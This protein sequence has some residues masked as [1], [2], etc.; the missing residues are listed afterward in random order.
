MKTWEKDGMRGAALVLALVMLV[1]LSLMGITAV[2]TSGT[3]IFIA[4]NQRVG[5]Q[6][7]YCADAGL[8]RVIADH[9]Y[10]LASTSSSPDWSNSSLLTPTGSVSFTTT[11]APL[12]TSLINRPTESNWLVSNDIVLYADGDSSGWVTPSTSPCKYQVRLLRVSGKTSEIYIRSRGEQTIGGVTNAKV[13]VAHLKVED[14][15]PWSSAVFGGSGSGGTI[16]GNVAVHGT[17]HLL[18]TGATSSTTVWD[19]TGSSGVY[20]NYRDGVSGGIPT[21]LKNRI[22]AQTTLDAKLRVKVGKVG[23]SGS[24]TI[25]E[26]SSCTT[27]KCA[28]DGIYVTDGMTGATSSNT[29][30]DNGF[31]NAYDLGNKLKMPSLKNSAVSG[32]LDA[33]SPTVEQDFNFG[34][35]SGSAA[36]VLTSNAWSNTATALTSLCTINSDTGAFRSVI[37]SN[38]ISW[39]K[40]GKIL[41]I[42]G[43][44]SLESVWCS[45]NL[46]TIGKGSPAETILY[47]GRGTIF[48]GTDI[49]HGGTYPSITIK[50]ALVTLDSSTSTY[51]K[52]FPYDHALGLMTGK[53]LTM[54]DPDSGTDKAMMAAIF[55]EQSATIGKALNFGGSILTST[56]TITQVPSFFYV[57]ALSD[58][59]PPGM[60]ATQPIWDFS[61]REIYEVQNPQL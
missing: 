53:T 14:A 48:A 16:T 10:E 58:N 42:N 47:S 20:N 13:L 28:L 35:Y 12:S 57:P 30:S 2:L 15:S 39:D 55:A 34:T 46:F 59:I 17:V 9:L 33:G 18:G 36:L 26:S 44:I 29:Y 32:G 56:V 61:V 31:P 19:M 43:K 21:A 41:V 27:G 38:L 6:T 4:G 24:S 50:G 23:Q 25:G 5:N 7:F 3:G 51:R 37:G 45:G 1:I 52:D 22:Q 49:N 11:G 40:N 54:D 60:P 8:D